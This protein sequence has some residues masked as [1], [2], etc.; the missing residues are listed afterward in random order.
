MLESQS[1][2]STA[3]TGGASSNETPLTQ[4][5]KYISEVEEHKV[6]QSDSPLVFWAKRK[7]VYGLI[8]NLAEDLL[9]APASQAY[10]ERIFSVCGILTN[11]RRN[12]MSASLQMRACLKLNHRVLSDE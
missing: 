11:G 4:L 1:I 2:L 5:N 3:A 10:V 6:E 8:A 7:P 9:A 12:R